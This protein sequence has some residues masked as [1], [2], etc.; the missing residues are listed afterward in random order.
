MVVV[1]APPVETP[2]GTEAG[3]IRDAKLR[4]ARRRKRSAALVGGLAVL[5]LLSAWLATGGGSGSRPAG[6]THARVAALGG[7]RRLARPGEW[8]I[9]PALGGGSYG[10]CIHEE[11]GGSCATVP[12]E[13]IAGQRGTAR[14]AIGTLAG[15]T[16]AGREQRI[17]AL[18]SSSVHG[19]L[20]RG[21]AV[22][23]LWR[24]ALSYDLRLAQI[25]LVRPRY[26]APT[27]PLLAIGAG[28][29]RLGLLREQSVGPVSAIHWWQKPA[30]SAPGPCQIRAHGLPG[31]E[32]EWG[33]VAAA[34]RSYP[35]KIIGRAFFSC[36]DTEYYLHKWPLETAILLDAQ[37]P[38]S[39]PAAIPGM[40]PVAGAPGLFNAPGGFDGEITAVRQANRWLAVAG[41]S[42]LA[43]R[44]DVLRHLTTSVA[45]G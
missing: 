16:G 4:Q 11:G 1:E 40:T 18:L 3:A 5:G 36:A 25:V 43:Q 41:G 32:P 26:G 42:G 28:G 35:A 22:T 31:L 33:H 37:H 21:K 12:A 10:W 39:A 13:T 38:G 2:T 7:A 14:V 20:A 30:R 29:R 34:I 24:A 6:A 45:W 27:P 17:T 19:V 23:V 15:S 8:R 44:I 9:S